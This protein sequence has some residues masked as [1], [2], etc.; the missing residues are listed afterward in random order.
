MRMSLFS[1]AAALCASKP[2]QAAQVTITGSVQPC[3]DRSRFDALGSTKV[4]APGS[5]MGSRAPL[6]LGRRLGDDGRH[7]FGIDVESE[8]GQGT[9]GDFPRPQR[10]A[11]ANI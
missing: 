8:E 10:R 2:A 9:S 5:V 7:A 3:I 11:G 4:A 6:W 1:A